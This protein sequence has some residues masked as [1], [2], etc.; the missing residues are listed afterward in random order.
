MTTSNNNQDNIERFKTM[1]QAVV[2]D[3]QWETLLDQLPD[4]VEAQLN[5]R[6]YTAE[7]PALATALDASPELA[8]AYQHLYDLEQALAT[9]QLPLATPPGKPNLHFLPQPNTTPSL[10]GRLRDAVQ[11]TG[12]KIQLQ[13]DE[14]LFSLLAP[15]PAIGSTRSNTVN[16]YNTHLAHLT[17]EQ[18][19]HLQLELTVDIYQNETDPTDCLVEVN[20]IPEGKSWPE[21]EGSLVV[22]HYA[23]THLTAET[24]SWGNASFTDLPAAGIQT[25]QLE[26]HPA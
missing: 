18:L 23:E 1:L 26:I 24:D 21:L 2:G 15:P 5:G 16:R 14:A 4:Y 6:N 12:A 11:K 19:P 17:A 9:D 20:V 8:T 10:A 7:F 22:I 3:E 25:L 13:L